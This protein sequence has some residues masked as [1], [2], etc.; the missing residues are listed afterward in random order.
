VSIGHTEWGSRVSSAH[1]ADAGI[2]G[3]AIAAGKGRT[4]ES[5]QCDNRQV[6]LELKL[7]D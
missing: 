7:L 2:H 6:G 1:A 4:E 5:M 3:P